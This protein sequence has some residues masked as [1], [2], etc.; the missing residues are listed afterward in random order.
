MA[1]R[2][3]IHKLQHEEPLHPVSPVEP[4]PSPDVTALVPGD[5][6]TV[7]LGANEKKGVVRKPTPKPK[8]TESNKPRPKRTNAD[9]DPKT[10]GSKAIVEVKP[11]PNV[12]DKLLQGL[13]LS[14]RCQA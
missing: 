3:E 11:C 9:K 14:S 2:L 4:T 12:F 8:Y 7:G 5:S 6:S 13:N 1:D 10:E